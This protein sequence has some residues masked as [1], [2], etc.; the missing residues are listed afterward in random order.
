MISG[1]EIKKI[2]Y[3]FAGIL[4]LSLIAALVVNLLMV[5][6]V[7]RDA[8]KQASTYT[9]LNEKCAKIY[10]LD[11][12]RIA[13]AAKAAAGKEFHYSNSVSEVAARWKIPTDQ[14][15]L[16]VRS[17]RQSKDT[18]TQ[19]ARVAIDEVSVSTFAKFLSQILYEWPNLECQTIKL[20]SER[21]Q[22]D[23]WKATIDFIYTLN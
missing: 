18:R 2:N 13:N 20:I 4:L 9:Q 3:W 21:E 6:S 7:A 14:Y 10:E 1:Y 19:N 23:T 16:N 12:A 8:Q 15:N 22:K 17:I 5:P 11:P